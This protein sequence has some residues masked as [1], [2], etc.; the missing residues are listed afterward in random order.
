MKKFLFYALPILI[1]L[2][3][4]AMRKNQ[5]DDSYR[6]LK[7]MTGFLHR[8]SEQIGDN[9]FIVNSVGVSEDFPEY[10]EVRRLDDNRL[11]KRF[12]FP[13]GQSSYNLTVI[14]NTTFVANHI[15]KLGKLPQKNFSVNNIENATTR[16]LP[17]P[18]TSTSC[19][20]RLTDREVVVGGWADTDAIL[21]YD[22]RTNKPSGFNTGKAAITALASLP[23]NSNQILSG[24]YGATT[25]KLWDARKPNK[26]MHE[27][28]G[29][30]DSVTGISATINKHSLWPHVVSIQN[31]SGII[32]N[33]QDSI[34]YRTFSI[35]KKM[36]MLKALRNQYIATIGEWGHEIFLFD[37][38]GNLI[39][40]LR[41]DYEDPDLY[42]TCVNELSNNDILATGE[43]YI[44]LYRT[45]TE[46]KRADYEDDFDA[47]IDALETGIETVVSG[48]GDVVLKIGDICEDI[49]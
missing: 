14:D 3:V 19:L 44:K 40:T 17:G 9:N 42:L 37:L 22:L 2:H 46:Q 43:G 35:G 13:K 31:E 18:G 38:H 41:A 5:Q 27:L 26:P 6:T 15:P 11:G 45:P 25:I 33:L 24:Q 7:G 1:T 34:P 29:H 47:D 32:W 21:L 49:F 39:K 12:Q 4:Q 48:V 10:A 20:V 23:N 16:F 36:L 8:M 28:K 30:T